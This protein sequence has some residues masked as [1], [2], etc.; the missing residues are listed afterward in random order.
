MRERLWALWCRIFHV[1]H[2]LIMQLPEDD[3]MLRGCLC[4]K[5]RYFHVFEVELMKINGRDL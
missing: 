4:K 1:D 2:W 5:C 3:V